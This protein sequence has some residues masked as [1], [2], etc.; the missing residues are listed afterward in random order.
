MLARPLNVFAAAILLTGIAACTNDDQ[1]EA[2]PYLDPARPIAER[3]DDLLGRMSLDDKVGQM[4]QAERG[5][6]TA[7][8]ITE[9]RIGSVLSGGGSAPGTNTP[10]GWADMYDDFQRGA[11]ATP[12]K[13]PMIYGIDAVHGNNNVAGAT[14]FP[15]NIGLGA[16]RDPELVRRIGQATAAEVAGVGLDWTFAPCVCVARDDRWG[17]TYESYGED[18]ALV[19]SMTTQITGLQGGPHRVLATAKHYVGDGGT[20]GGDDQGVTD[21]GEQELRRIH[22]EPYREAIQRGVGSVMVSFSSYDGTKMHANQPLVTEV[23]KGELGFTG[24]VVS[25]WNGID[26]IDGK[27]GFT[28]DEVVA[29][30]NAGL[31]MVMVPEEWQ[32]FVTELKGAVEDN[33]IPMSRIDDANRRIL[34][35]KFTFGL[36]EQPYT[37]RSLAGLV[38]SAEH[39]ELARDAVRKSLVLLK[40][41]RNALPLAK[42]RKI[43]V[44]GKSADDLGNQSGGWTMSW[45]GKSGPTLTGTSLLEGLREV[46]GDRVI[47]DRDGNGAD[48]TYDAVVAVVGEQP[49]AE[50]EGDR[51][52]GLRLDEDDRKVLDRL[53]QAGVPVVVVLV[54]GRPLAVD[55]DEMDALVAAWLPGSE[56]AGVADVLFGDHPPTG[57]LPVTWPRSPDQ[58]PINVND[59]KSGLF[60][61]GAGLTYPK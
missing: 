16:T 53:R 20:K 44:A 18:P 25:D 33:R 14:I 55:I 51:P 40:N 57:K 5:S 37:D 7:A 8:Q 9:F 4:T 60:P 54:S 1:T 35:Q 19:S 23:L 32:R 47:Y 10:A 38:G 3:V 2:L 56:G 26:Q 61:Y 43:F 59:G 27:K 28:R 52:D 13:I 11:L 21:V 48:E 45:Q 34:T 36:F 22:L 6:I 31:D 41:D 29:A 12:L 17:R 30:V 39:R 49:Y 15:H 46:A 42:D 50:Y 24:F 58:Q